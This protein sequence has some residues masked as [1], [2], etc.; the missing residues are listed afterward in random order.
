MN[1]R[2]VKFWWV[3]AA[4]A[5]LASGC[6]GAADKKDAIAA[7]ETAVLAS[8]DLA[9]VARAELS[10]GVAVQGTLEP[11]VDVQ[12]ISPYPELID[13]VLVKEGQ[14]VR[15]GQAMARFR[16]E[17]L[18]PAA[19]SAE[20]QRKIAAADY[21]RMKNLFKEGAVAQR[22]VDNAEAVVRSAEAAAALARKR[23]DDATVAAPVDG[24]VATRFVQSGDRVGDGDPLF[25]LVNTDE[26]EFAASVPTDALAAVRP[27]APVVLAVSGMS[28]TT[29]AG[30]VARV[31]ATVDAATRQVKVYVVV[32]N[33]DHRLAGDMFATGRIL[34]ETKTSALAVPSSGVRVDPDGST[35]VWVV[36]GGKA[37]RR[38]V[39]TGVRDESRDVIEV[40]GGLR[41]GETVV[42][43]PIEGLV[44]GQPVQVTGEPGAASKAAAGAASAAGAEAAG[45]P[46]AG[47]RR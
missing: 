46:A 24:V 20:A 47:S 9:R 25:R 16:T 12:I 31:N 29:L 41:E 27:G 7:P 35:F 43:G 38:V 3:A 5:A 1:D 13:Q 34:L 44:P 36:N 42:V 32:P 17:S 37:D 21:E 11:A 28:G 33:H 40:V 39:R 30:R 18:E 26:L 10:T 22:D 8:R 45:Q 23:L 6:G 15:R 19:V 4:L 14:P 2:T